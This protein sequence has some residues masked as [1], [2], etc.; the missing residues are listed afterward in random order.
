MQIAPRLLEAR[1]HR[2]LRFGQLGFSEFLV[3]WPEFKTLLVADDFAP[4]QGRANG[5]P[6]MVELPGFCSDEHQHVPINTRRAAALREN[7]LRFDQ[8]FGAVAPIV[9]VFDAQHD[10]THSTRLI[11]HFC[12]GS[13]RDLDSVELPTICEAVHVF[14][15][16]CVDRDVDQC[17]LDLRRLIRRDAIEAGRHGIPVATK[18]SVHE[19]GLVRQPPKRIGED[20]RAF[21]GLHDTEVDLLVVEAGVLLLGSGRG[22]HE[23]RAGDAPGRRITVKVGRRLIDLVGG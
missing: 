14:S 19:L 20:R 22:S 5:I 3:T 12:R 11:W 16:F 13:R 1:F 17:R 8:R 23:N 4:S 10:G 15:E 6:Q 2:L 21:A 18:V 9:G 7:V